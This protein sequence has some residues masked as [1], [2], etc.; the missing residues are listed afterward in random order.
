MSNIT[1]KRVTANQ[2]PW[3]DLDSSWDR[4]V[5]QT[6]EWLDYLAET[7]GAREVFAQVC[8][9]SSTV[10]YFVGMTV[11]KCGLKVL[12]SPM[13][14]WTTPYMGFNLPESFQR[15]GALRALPEFAFDE[16]GCVHLEVCDRF[17]DPQQAASL[18]F[19]RSNYS[20]Y[21][22]DLTGT[23]DEL[24]GR[25][26]SDRRSN[27]RKAKKCG[28]EIEESNDEDF[29]VDYYEQLKQVFAKH[30]RFPPIA[31]IEFVL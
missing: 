1:L 9:G 6:R 27:I 19:Q 18:P 17:L 3:S 20:T 31:S 30:G 21:L 8:E 29:A 23:E 11:R 15:E 14:G 5:F 2:I 7:Q 24:F 28:V 26:T 12:G 4:T 25:M 16:L 10:G 22:S 13:P